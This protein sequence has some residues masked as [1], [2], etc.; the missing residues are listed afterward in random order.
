MFVDCLLLV[1]CQTREIPE[2]LEYDRKY[3]LIPL[4]DIAQSG[5]SLTW[6]HFESQPC[7]VEI[8]M[9]DSNDK[10]VSWMPER[11]VTGFRPEGEYWDPSRARYI[12]VEVTGL[13][14]GYNR[15]NKIA[16]LFW[17]EGDSTR[18]KPVIRYMAT[19][20]LAIPF[21]AAIGVESV[22]FNYRSFQD[23]TVTL[24]LYTL[25]AQRLLYSRRFYGVQSPL[26][27]ENR[28]SSL[29]Q[30]Y[31]TDV[32]ATTSGSNPAQTIVYLMALINPERTANPIKW[33]DE[34]QNSRGVVGY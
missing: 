18:M 15:Y 12:R 16:L 26:V 22:L 5:R 20:R 6:A 29:V 7:D 2:Q 30:D 32:V 24:K 1:G 25:D 10:S 13:M 31:Y 34:L 28:D 23:D 33:S 27:W 4:S 8:V 14:P 11:E 17:S 9:V 3:F 21:P 19:S